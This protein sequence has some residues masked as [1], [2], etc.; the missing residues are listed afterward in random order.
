MSEHISPRPGRRP[1]RVT[2]TDTG[3]VNIDTAGDGKPPTP[4]FG[5]KDFD[6][7]RTFAQAILRAVSEGRPEHTDPVIETT[8]TPKEKK[9]RLA[10]ERRAALKAAPKPEEGA[11]DD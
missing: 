1:L 4:M 2:T 6:E 5:F 9:N 3:K 7:A 8:E 10:R 11:S